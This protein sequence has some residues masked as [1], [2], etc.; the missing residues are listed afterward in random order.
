MRFAL[1]TGQS[2]VPPE[3]LQIVHQIAPLLVGAVRRVG[4]QPRE[5][6][7]H[8]VRHDGS[9]VVE[10]RK[11]PVVRANARLARKIRTDAPCAPQMRIVED[12]FPGQ[13][14]FAET[15]HVAFKITDLL[16]VAISA[17]FAAVD[18][19]TALL[20]RGQ[21]RGAFRLRTAD[22]LFERASRPHSEEQDR[23]GKEAHATEARHQIRH[24]Q[25]AFHGSSRASM[26]AISATGSR[27]ISR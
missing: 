18:G 16:R 9:R 7:H 21:R 1:R 13:R 4:E 27:P 17:T 2:T 3:R 26:G 11:L 20:A 12:R 6:G 8:G 23:H 5:R 10:M 19:A 15:P 25:Q 24:P 22:L 14:G